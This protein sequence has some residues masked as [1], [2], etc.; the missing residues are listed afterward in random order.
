M[1]DDNRQKIIPQT[2]IV[3]FIRRNCPKCGLLSYHRFIVSGVFDC[4]SCGARWVDEKKA[5]NGP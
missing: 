3:L 4:E 5:E 1:A 2:P